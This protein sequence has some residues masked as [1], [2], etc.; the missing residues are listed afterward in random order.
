MCNG[1]LGDGFQ[2]SSHGQVAAELVQLDR[3]GFTALDCLG[4]SAHRGGQLADH[5]ANG[6]QVQRR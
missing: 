5:D 3:F 4:L 2:I 1:S 6:Q